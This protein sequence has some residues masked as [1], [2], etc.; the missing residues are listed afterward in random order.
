VAADGTSTKTDAEDWP[1]NPPVVDLYDPNLP[2]QEIHRDEF[3]RAW[4]TAQRQ[5]ED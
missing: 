4:A 3:E 5:K 2:G 1:F